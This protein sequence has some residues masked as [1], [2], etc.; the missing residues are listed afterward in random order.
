MAPK[1]H[2]RFADIED[3]SRQPDIKPSLDKSNPL[4]DRAPSKKRKRS[5]LQEIK[6]GNQSIQENS[7]FELSPR[8]QHARD[9]KPRSLPTTFSS[10]NH[11]TLKSKA[12]ALEAV[13]KKLPVWSHSEE[14]RNELQLRDVVIISGETGSGKSTQVPQILLDLCKAQSS[15]VGGCIAITQPRRVAAITLARRV[16]EEMAT[17]LG[18]SSPASKVG[19]SVRFDNSTSVSTKIKYLT[20]GMLLQEMLRDPWLRQYS[21][22]IVDEVHER[23]VNVDL[24]LGFLR[25][26]AC[27]DRSGRSGVPIKVI[28]MSATADTA[29]LQEF[30]EAGFSAVPH[31]LTSNGQ[32]QSLREE[33]QTALRDDSPEWSGIIS[34]DGEDETPNKSKSFSDT[35]S[36]RVSAIHIKGRQYPV[37]VHYTPKPVQDWI[38]AALRTVLQINYK[39]PLPGDI[40]VFLTGQETIE[41][42]E[43]LL[44]E[45][46]PRL[47]SEVPKLLVLPLFAA[48][49]QSQQQKVFQPGPP[50]T[51]KVILATNIAETSV[52]V[53]GVRFVIDCGL[54]KRK[55]YRTSL[56]LDSLL[57]KPISKSAATQRKGRAGREAPGQ[58]YRLYTEQDYN[59]LQDHTVPEILRCDLNQ[60]ILNM[61]ARGTQDVL[62]FPFL[63]RPP[64]EAVE[65]A[66]L[67]LYHLGA[68]R[69]TGDISNIGI[70]IAKLPLSTSLGRVLLAAAEPEADC[71]AEAIDIISCLSVENIFL[72]LSSHEDAKEKVESA[73]RELFRREGDHMTLLATIRAYLEENSDRKAWADRY[74]VSHRALRSVLDVRK[75]LLA[76]CKALQLPLSADEHVKTQL[77]PER[78]TAL[79]KCFVRGFIA[80]TA[81]PVQGGDYRTIFGK[82][83]VTIHPSSV[84]FGRGKLEAIMYNEHVFTNRS[85]A[86]GVCA[87]QIDW[88]RE[89]L[90]TL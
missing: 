79:L 88:I 24:I 48:L 70:K 56:G 74:C 71:L 61:K 41:S 80:N 57:V 2:H 43:S 84:L 83:A 28:V 49:P 69:D 34:D 9:P 67:H 59:R 58:C 45:Y 1:I 4:H 15:K 23:S 51:R 52:T 13:R 17:P 31:T 11:G 38:D 72:Q 12:Q 87:V 86:R 60:A 77:S 37:T 40:L 22:V 39:E 32:P 78:T 55:Q 26:M 64:R 5:S 76:Q 50:M 44:N 33:D 85:Y 3:V 19:Y 18:S 21:A 75:Q 90:D 16:A 10:A 66:L 27:G 46:A 6:P 29:G 81:L 65:K 35:S 7:K 20:E 73:R 62:S 30:F 53:G 36:S 42:L 8:N 68:L 47:K 89:V 82:Q 25:N 63:S 14:I 54:H